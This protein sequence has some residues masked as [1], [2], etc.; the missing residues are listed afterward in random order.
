MTLTVS[1]VLTACPEALIDAAGQVGLSATAA[2]ADISGERANLVTLA[3]NWGGSAATAAQLH[4]AE[5]LAGQERYRAKLLAMQQVLASGGATLSEIRGELAALVTG[6]LATFWHI[7]D[8]GSVSP[9]LLLQEYAA[10]SAV[11]ELQVLL[12]GYGLEREIRQLLAEF[13]L[14]DIRTADSLRAFADEAAPH[15]QASTPV[16]APPAPGTAAEPQHPEASPGSQAETGTVSHADPQTPHSGTPDSQHPEAQPDTQPDPHA[17][18][19][20]P[21]THPGLATPNSVPGPHDDDP[22][23]QTGQTPTLAGSPGDSPRMR[24]A[25]GSSDQVRLQDNPPGFTGPAGPARDAAW[26]SYLAQHNALAPGAVTPK[27]VLPNPDAV[28]D[29]GLKTVGAAAKQQG[30]S[31]TWGGGHLPGKPGVSRGWRNDSADASWT[32]NDQNRTGF[33]CS[34]LARFAAAEG[35]GF[36][37]NDNN[38]GNTVGQEAALTAAGGQGRVVPDSVLTPGDLIY[39]GPPGGSHHVVVYAGNGMVVQAQGSG[40]P[41]EV[42]PIDLSEQHRNI[43]LA[44]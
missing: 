4:G 10:L 27:T 6:D 20:P 13:E 31:Y 32:F 15:P 21:E 42:S 3:G 41:V 37:I 30:V 17:E 40:E 16:A 33:D 35:Y 22:Q 18:A 14:A 29:K 44:N 12:M 38:I 39:Y 26:Q 43:H 5:L 24:V 34:G 11:T 7:G 8:D 25:S 36:D 9:G 1:R 23:Y 19:K 28:S 2:E